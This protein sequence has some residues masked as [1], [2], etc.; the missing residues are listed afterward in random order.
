MRLDSDAI[1]NQARENGGQVE[2]TIETVLDF[3]EIAVGILCEVERMVSTGECCLQIAEQGIDG[4]EL[5]QLDA[6]RA[7]AC[8]R[9]N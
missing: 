8:D 4:P 9:G 1:A 6:G 5:R 3:T 2:S 7:A